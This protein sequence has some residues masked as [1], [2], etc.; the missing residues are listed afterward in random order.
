MTFTYNNLVPATN[1]DPSADQPEMLINTASINS[2]I[3][4]DHVGF[5]ANG[6]G[7]HKFVRLLNP[8]SYAFTLP[9]GAANE[10]M[11]SALTTGAVT[12]IYYR[13]DST[14]DQYQLTRTISASKT[15]FGTNNAYP[16]NASPAGATTTGGWTF[17]PGGLLLQY[18]T[19]TA[20]GN[21]ST[22][23]SFPIAFTST[24]FA[25]TISIKRNSG[26]NDNLF[27]NSKS[28]TT[29]TYFASTSNAGFQSFDW[30]AIGV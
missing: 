25:M 1:N 24:P 3:A 9:L 13:P 6:G 26:S 23:V 19:V 17:L 15:K 16:S 10:G 5:N 28:S 27:I 30:M 2:I 29:F 12:D 14:T 20:P 7:K 4:V 11:L 22:T 21:P 18:G 8:T